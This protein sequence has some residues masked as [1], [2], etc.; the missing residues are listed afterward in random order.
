MQLSNTELLD[1][2]TEG[3]GNS[4]LRKE[5]SE[6]RKDDAQAQPSP[7]L[8]F[9]LPGSPLTDLRLLESRDRH[10]ARKAPPSKERS[11]FQSKLLK[12]PFGTYTSTLYVTKLTYM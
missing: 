6:L 4:Q 11:S 8:Q 2:M 9:G 1:L 5:G 10:K 12:N 7:D 3:K